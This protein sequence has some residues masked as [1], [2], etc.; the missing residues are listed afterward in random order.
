MQQISIDEAAMMCDNFDQEHREHRSSW[1]D[2]DIHEFSFGCPQCNVY[3]S[4][5]ID[6]SFNTFRD[7]LARD[8]VVLF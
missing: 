6:D 1:L 4:F 3:A 8:G 2:G 7:I 5:R